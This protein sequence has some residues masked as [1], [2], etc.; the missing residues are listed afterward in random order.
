MSGRQMDSRYWLAQ[1][2]ASATNREN[3]EIPERGLVWRTG[4]ACFVHGDIIIAHIYQV[5]RRNLLSSR[6]LAKKSLERNKKE[7][8]KKQTPS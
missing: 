7:T 5:E 4:I 6:S 2:N 1:V 8:E 3:G